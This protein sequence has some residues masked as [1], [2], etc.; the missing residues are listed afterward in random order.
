MLQIR[1]G[2][3]SLNR[4]EVILAL[5]HQDH[6]STPYLF[7]TLTLPI[8]SSVYR[9]S[10]REEDKPFVLIRSNLPLVKRYIC[11]IKGGTLGSLYEGTKIALSDTT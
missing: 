11:T 1:L 9:Y 10:L 7:H 6:N 4:V 8:M 3:Q 2:I 5:L